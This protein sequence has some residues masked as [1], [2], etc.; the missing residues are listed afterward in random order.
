MTTDNDSQDGDYELFIDKIVFDRF[1]LVLN[2]F[3]IEK[4]VCQYHFGR[5]PIEAFSPDFMD[6]LELK[7]ILRRLADPTLMSNLEKVASKG[8]LE[9]KSMVVDITRSVIEGRDITVAIQRTQ[10]PDSMKM[11]PGSYLVAKIPRKG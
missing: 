8:V 5:I 4:D 9:E 3:S 11:V 10:G 7:N 1:G 2:W 6:G